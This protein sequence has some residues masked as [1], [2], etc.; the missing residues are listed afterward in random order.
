MRGGYVH[1]RVLA[2]SIKQKAL[3]LGVQVECEVTIEVE[4]R[5][6]YGDLL[7]QGGDKRILVEVEMS[8]KR[9]DKDLVKATALKVCEV[10]IVVP[11][12]KVAELVRRK[13]KQLMI[14]PGV[15]RLFILLLPQALQRLEELFEL[16][17]G[18]NVEKEN[19]RK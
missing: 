10:W 13:I 15:T 11:N 6:L 1:N 9:I 5:I 16:N 14:V 12:P 17:S 4:R 2:D 7:I 3:Q 8:S 19:K 18:S